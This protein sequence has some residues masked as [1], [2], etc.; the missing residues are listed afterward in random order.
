MEIST[1]QEP[2]Y[3]SDL[4]TSNSSRVNEGD[5]QT[6]NLYARQSFLEINRNP[7][8]TTKIGKHVI[9]IG[10]RKGKVFSGILSGFS[11]R[12]KA[13]TWCYEL[14]GMKLSSADGDWLYFFSLD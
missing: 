12:C 2:Y 8:E 3:Q 4:R 10:D 7:N 6:A 1:N 11:Q 5:S 14:G 13:G 9:N